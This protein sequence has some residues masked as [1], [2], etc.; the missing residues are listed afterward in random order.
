MRLELRGVQ[1]AR[2]R[3]L[4]YIAL[5]TPD[6]TSAMPLDRPFKFMAEDLGLAPETFY[7]TL[8]ELEK[9]GLISRTRNSISVVSSVC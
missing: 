4:Q 8:A 7:R 6:G 1:S 3:L 2:K 5:S 9:N